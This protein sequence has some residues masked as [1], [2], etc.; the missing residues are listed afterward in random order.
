MYGWKVNRAKAAVLSSLYP[1][2]DLHRGGNLKG[3]PVLFC[4]RL[5]GIN[6]SVSIIWVFADFPQVVSGLG[7]VGF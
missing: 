1:S 2:Q 6:S 3:N 7:Q 5:I 4:Y